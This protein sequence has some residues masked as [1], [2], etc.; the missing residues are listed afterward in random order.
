VDYYQVYFSVLAALGPRDPT[1]CPLALGIIGQV[2]ASGYEAE[3]PDIT[4]NITAAQL[5]CSGGGPGLIETTATPASGTA[6]PAVT[7][8]P[9]PTEAPAE[10]S[11]EAPTP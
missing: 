2:R 4:T 10:G 1:Y 9:Y 8:T 5:E 6:L 7:S 3:R 11:A